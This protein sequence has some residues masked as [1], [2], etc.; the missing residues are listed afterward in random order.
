M[1]RAALLALLLAALRSTA[2]ANETSFTII[3]VPG[4]FVT[5]GRSFHY[6]AN[7]AT[8]YVYI[9][10]PF[11]GVAIDITTA[12]HDFDG[13]W[14]VDFANATKTPLMPGMYQ[15][16]VRYR[17]G[18][19]DQNWIGVTSFNGCNMISGSFEVL[20]ATYDAAGN[21]VSFWAKFTQSCDGFPAVSGE[22]KI[23]VPE[24]ATIPAAGPA[25]LLA[26]GFGLAAVAVYLLRR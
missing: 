13:M 15:N 1:R 12:S 9:D 23:N 2:A 4:D 26:L 18:P 25:G 20:L 19:Y 11:H 22:V 16:A 7:D 24:A 21:V 14:F 10:D 3:G 5:E 8:F 17:S 6:T